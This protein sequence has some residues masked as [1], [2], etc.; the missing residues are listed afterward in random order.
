MGRERLTAVE[1]HA[2]AISRELKD[3]LSL[4]LEYVQGSD[5]FMR[6]DVQEKQ[7]LAFKLI[8]KPVEAIFG[9]LNYMPLDVLP[10]DDAKESLWSLVRRKQMSNAF[11]A[12]LLP[13]DCRRLM[14]SDIIQ[15]STDSCF[16]GLLLVVYLITALS[17]SLKNTEYG[18]ILSNFRII[19]KRRG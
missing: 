3:I 4:Q 13:E 18:S 15:S 2:N 19:A 1:A 11:S 7:P 14:N 5:F 17:I 16:P 10:Y 9:L 6:I 8:S 12:W